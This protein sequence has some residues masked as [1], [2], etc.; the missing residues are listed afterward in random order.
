MGKGPGMISIYRLLLLMTLGTMLA[1]LVNA[2]EADSVTTGTLLQQIGCVGGLVVLPHG[3][4]LASVIAQQPG[5][6]VLCM[7]HDA[8]AAQAAAATADRAGLLGRS[9]Y[10]MEADG[11]AL[12]LADGLANL[13]LVDDATDATLSQL[14]AAELARV[15]AP[16]TGCVAVGAPKPGKLSKGKLVAWAAALGKDWTITDGTAGLFAVFHKPVTPGTD[17]WPMRRHGAD[18]NFAS[19]D[20]V[21]RWPLLTQWTAKPL[22]AGNPVTLEGAGYLVQVSCRADGV[23]SSGNI[24]RVRDAN[25]GLLRWERKLSDGDCGA[26]SRNS[27]MCIIGDQLLILDSDGPHVR[28]LALADGSDRGVIDGAALGTQLKWIAPRGTQLLLMAGVN[29]PWYETTETWKYWIASWDQWQ[30]NGSIPGRGKTLAAI[31]QAS[32]KIVWRHDEVDAVFDESMIAA[33]GDRVYAYLRDGRLLCLDANT[34]A[35]C[36]CSDAVKGLFGFKQEFDD[37]GN[38]GGVIVNNGVVMINE[39]GSSFGNHDKTGLAVCDAADGK[40]LWKMDG[41]VNAVIA[42]DH[43]YIKLAW[44][45]GSIRQ[46]R[47]GADIRPFQSGN[48]C[49]QFTI[50]PNLVVGQWGVLL[51]RAMPDGDRKVVDLDFLKSACLNGSQI[52]NGMYYQPSVQCRCPGSYGNSARVPVGT[53]WSEK[54]EADAGRLRRGGTA[55]GATAPS[56]ADW[57]TGNADVSRRGSSAALVAATGTLLWQHA[58]AAP[59][60]NPSKGTA[61]CQ[62][63]YE[64]PQAAVVD[65]RV[66][67]GSLDGAVR[68]LDLRTGKL[69]WTRYLGGPISATPTLTLERV[70]IG[71]WDGNVYCLDAGDGH[72]LWRFRAAPKTRLIQLYGHLSSTW[73]VTGGVLVQ[74]GNAYSAAC[75]LPAD[76][77]AVMALNAVTGALVWE[78]RGNAPDD[79]A[80][81]LNAYAFPIGQLAIGQGRLWSHLSS[82]D[83]ATGKPIS[84]ALP[85][86]DLHRAY[87]EGR[88]TGFCDGYVLCGGRLFWNEQHAFIDHQPMVMAWL[89]VDMTGA[90]RSTAVIPMTHTQMMPAWNNDCVAQIA[91]NTYAKPGP[92][93]REVL[94]EVQLWDWARMKP[95]MENPDTFLDTKIF[96]TDWPFNNANK[97][98]IKVRHQARTDSVDDT[99]PFTFP[100]LRWRN[101]GWLNVAAVML[102]ADAV[103]IAGQV[104]SDD[105]KT[106]AWALRVCELADGKIRWQ[107]RLPSE[108]VYDGLSLGRNGS[109]IV[110]LLD[111]GIACFGV[112]Q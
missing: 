74:G 61:G 24:L 73:P 81:N 92:H 105:A 44:G 4:T 96:P 106:P 41:G 107:A 15:A 71:A 26:L 52:A 7:E 91:W 49:G 95:W 80:K 110:Q 14:N 29:D 22:F 63:S 75:G 27:D 37:R 38:L 55:M 35:Q 47:T 58:L 82:W 65:N 16:E 21:C 3:G 90:A 62:T 108:P 93:P 6:M 11:P 45:G 94:D 86:F 28:R 36:W 13:V 46:L 64:A 1:P 104:L 84:C 112:E 69:L 31:E 12:P 5:A 33:Q 111:G 76:G 67:S 9:L 99:A 2:V 60:N 103:A 10:V 98:T 19:A 109:V 85:G 70:Y 40:L 66:Y 23:P 56:P 100:F 32:G 101:R 87:K 68:C 39:V 20:T 48:G 83:L 8:D 78:Q 54:P 30:K 25:N 77:Y 59:F 51:N 18:A 57:A 79:D 42:G 97:N 72:E 17:T 102:G 53:V 34:G 88:Y 43:V 89:P 50:S